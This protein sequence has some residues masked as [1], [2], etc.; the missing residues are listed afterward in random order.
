MRQLAALKYVGIHMGLGAPGPI[1]CILDRV[2]EACKAQ[3]KA[4]SCRDAADQNF[5]QIHYIQRHRRRRYR[6]V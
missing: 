6:Y 1:I 2:W 5:V 3:E 4:C